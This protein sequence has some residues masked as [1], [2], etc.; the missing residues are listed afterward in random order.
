M[1]RPAGPAADPGRGAGGDAEADA[2]RRGPDLAGCAAAKLDADVP[3]VAG[4]D[5]AD[6]VRLLP[7]PCRRAGLRLR[8]G[9]P[10]PAGRRRADDGVCPWRRRPWPLGGEGRRRRGAMPAPA[11]GRALPFP[12]FCISASPRW[13]WS[14][15]CNARG[16]RS[17]CLRR[18]TRWSSRRER[19][20]GRPSRSSLPS[21]DPT[22]P[23]PEAVAEEEL[24]PPP[25]PPLAMAEPPASGA[26]RAAGRGSGAVAARAGG[27]A[28]SRA[29]AAAA[30]RPPSAAAP[31]AP[32]RPAAAGGGAHRAAASCA[33]AGCC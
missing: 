32:P 13:R 29:G 22:E 17:R 1:L 9:K 30:G 10:R 20:S 27:G 7:G 21:P 25:L 28:N 19:R 5:A 24:P 14:R 16:R 3:A 6:H 18:P 12:C 15:P 8:A 11:S 26:G 2:R 31:P 4:T 33:A 23:V